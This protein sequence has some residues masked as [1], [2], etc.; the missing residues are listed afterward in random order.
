MTAPAGQRF[1]HLVRE[2]Q[3]IKGQAV[4]VQTFMIEGLAHLAAV[5]PEVAYEDDSSPARF[6]VRLGAR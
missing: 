1:E 6:C 5:L 2:H 3:E 4:H